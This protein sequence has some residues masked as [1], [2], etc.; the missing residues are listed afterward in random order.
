MRTLRFKKL[1]LTLLS[2]FC[3]LALI[4]FAEAAPKKKT[5]KETNQV[6]DSWGTP[7]IDARAVNNNQTDKSKEWYRGDFDGLDDD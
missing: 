4:G 1:T 7:V 2:I 5:S 6:E 3:S